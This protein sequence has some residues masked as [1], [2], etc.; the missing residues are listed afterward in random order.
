MTITLT[1]HADTIDQPSAQRCS[2][3]L[4]L[5]INLRNAAI[6]HRAH[7]DHN[8]SVSLWQLRRCAVMLQ[9]LVN[10]EELSIAHAYIDEMPIS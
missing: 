5:I 9:S 6:D 8:C 1:R 2:E 4:A 3:A 10:Y 7:C